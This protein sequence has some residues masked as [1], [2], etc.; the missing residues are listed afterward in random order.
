MEKQKVESIEELLGRLSSDAR[1][2]ATVRYVEGDL[3]TLTVAEARLLANK[4]PEHATAKVILSNKMSRFPGNQKI[5]MNRA[6]LEAMAYNSKAVYIKSQEE[7]PPA[8]G[9]TQ[10]ENASVFRKVLESDPAAAGVATYDT[11]QG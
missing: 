4:N 8:P 6:D 1:T 10:A 11:P 5:S 7:V 9:E 3:V 2:S